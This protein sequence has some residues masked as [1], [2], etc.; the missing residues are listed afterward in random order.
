MTQSQCLFRFCNGDAGVLRAT[1]IAT[2]E[3]PSHGPAPSRN[4]APPGSLSTVCLHLLAQDQHCGRSS[5]TVLCGGSHVGSLLGRGR[6]SRCQGRCPASSCKLWQALPLSECHS[7]REGRED[8]ELTAHGSSRSSD[9]GNRS[10]RGVEAGSRPEM[11]GDAADA[12]CFAV[13]PSYLQGVTYVS[14]V[15]VTATR[16]PCL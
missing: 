3:T 7:P 9:K 16:L 15:T 4:E 13:A 2:H 8:R 11:V 5:R 1:R 6:G 12:P 10:W 14:P